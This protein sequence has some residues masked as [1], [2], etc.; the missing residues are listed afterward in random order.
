MLVAE[1]RE[2]W[3]RWETAAETLLLVALATDDD[4]IFCMILLLMFANSYPSLLFDEPLEPFEF[5]E[6]LP[7]ELLRLIPLLSCCK[8]PPPP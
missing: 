4:S 2:R 6:R 1:N 7:F 8:L 3:E 5:S